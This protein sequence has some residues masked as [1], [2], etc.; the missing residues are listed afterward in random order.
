M[1]DH[2]TSLKSSFFRLAVVDLTKVKNGGKSH[3][4]AVLTL[5]DGDVAQ[6]QTG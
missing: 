3:F 4:L 5:D 1:R 2:C 6:V